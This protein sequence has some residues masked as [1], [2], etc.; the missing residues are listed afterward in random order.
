MT[1]DAAVHAALARSHFASLPDELVAQLTAG[2]MRVDV[3]A[4]TDLIAPG[5]APRL[6]LLVAGVGKTYLIAPNGRQATIRYARAGDIIASV[7]VYD[8]RP[9]AAGFCTQTP[10]SVLL[11]NMDLVP[12]VATPGVPGAN[13]FN[14]AIAAR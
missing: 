13:L 2:A 8:P 4:G 10:T 11:F 6:L 5:S 1:F 9:A 14:V 3:P 12:A 7:A